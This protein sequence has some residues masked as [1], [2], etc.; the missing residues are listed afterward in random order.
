MATR[1]NY[2][3]DEDIEVDLTSEEFQVT[4][5]QNRSFELKIG[6]KMFFFSPYS[7]EI[8][9]REE[10]NHPDFKQQSR[11]FNVKTLTGGRE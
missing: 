11:Y 8:L 4:F 1:R 9:T 10:I 7:T 3:S 2:D 6:R 5:N